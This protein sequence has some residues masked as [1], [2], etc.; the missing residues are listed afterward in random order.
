MEKPRITQESVAI[1][2]RLR[3]TFDRLKISEASMKDRD[4]L[5]LKLKEMKAQSEESK[6]NSK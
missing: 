4:W 6:N 5:I 2:W 3:M 1:T